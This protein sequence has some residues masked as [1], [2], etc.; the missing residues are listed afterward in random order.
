MPTRLTSSPPS[1][2]NN[3]AIELNALRRLFASFARALGS[4]ADISAVLETLFTSALDGAPDSPLSWQLPR[5]S[6]GS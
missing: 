6:L 4:T 3:S 1:H 2:C 5:S